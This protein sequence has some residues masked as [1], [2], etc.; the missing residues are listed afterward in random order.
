MA[1]S[2]GI[3]SAP[4]SFADVNSVLGTSHTSLG[5]LCTDNNINKWAKYKP[6]VDTI[7]NVSS[8][9]DANKNWLSSAT[10]WKG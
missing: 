5:L 9:M 1:N 3:I 6:V 10:W 4:V 7:I 8:Q 2:G